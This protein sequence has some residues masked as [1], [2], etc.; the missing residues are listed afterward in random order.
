MCAII[1]DKANNIQNCHELN[2][3]GHYVKNQML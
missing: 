1:F 3:T 2:T